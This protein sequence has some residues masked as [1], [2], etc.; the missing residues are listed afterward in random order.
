MI[1]D[2]LNIFRAIGAFCIAIGP[3]GTFLGILFLILCV[4]SCVYTFR[5]L[6]SSAPFNPDHWSRHKEA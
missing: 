3:V 2:I 5:E 4:Y 6:T 1:Q